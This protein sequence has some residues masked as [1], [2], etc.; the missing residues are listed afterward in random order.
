LHRVGGAASL[1]RVALTERERAILRFEQ[2]WW[3]LPGPKG[4]AITERLGL[5]PARYYQL[6]N[7]LL[8]DPEASAHDPLLVRRLLRQRRERRRTRVEGPGRQRYG[9]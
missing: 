9:R 1:V 3:Q 4:L 7:A 5:S 6:L 2:S 8:D